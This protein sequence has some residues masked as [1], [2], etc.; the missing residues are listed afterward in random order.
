MKQHI[1]LYRVLYPPK[2][3][4]PFTKR[5]TIIASLSLF[6]VL[7]VSGTAAWKIYELK[8]QYKFELTAKSIKETTFRNMKKEANSSI[9]H[10][11]QAAALAKL[12]TEFKKKTILIQQLEQHVTRASTGYFSHFVS[13]ARQDIKGIWL[14]HIILENIDNSNS[15]SLAG[16]TIQA[17]L[18]AKYLNN[19]SREKPF[20]GVS[21]IEM[22]VDDATLK[23]KQTE[24]Q[25]GKKLLSFIVSTEELDV[26]NKKGLSGS[27]Q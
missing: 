16:K 10:D 21:F 26:D 3:R 14:D 6:L 1:N 13:L 2:P 27:R 8:Q 18:V 22:R 19:L 24:N 20:N 11:Q 25:A 5:A 15:V 17:E 4:W 9:K 23:E 7:G 12:Q